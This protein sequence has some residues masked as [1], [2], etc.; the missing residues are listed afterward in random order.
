MDS[1]F[2]I[3]GLTLAIGAAAGMYLKPESAA[4]NSP[5]TSALQASSQATAAGLRT[6]NSGQPEYDNEL[7]EI[8]LLLQQETVARRKIE[9]ELKQLALQLAKLADNQPLTET[10][11]NSDAVANPHASNN[12]DWFNEQ[13]LIDNGMSEIQANELKTHFE[14]LELE[15]LYL[16]DQSVREQWDRAKLR[17]AMQQLTQKEDQL[18]TELNESAYDAYLYASGQTNRL[19][20][21]SVLASSQAGE[22]GIL[23]GDRIIR[24][25]G[26]RIYNWF[27]LQQVTSAGEISDLVELQVERNGEI[28]QLYTNRGPLGIRLNQLS[29]A[30]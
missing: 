12:S 27:D 20:V 25:S 24:Y 19:A 1:R 13:A 6:E 14:K 16:R 28:V 18:K 4:N 26:E 7:T 17:D 8:R 30:P 3:I 2:I 29:V 9:S 15:R 10:E 23:S 22:A 5:Q 21:A 11:N